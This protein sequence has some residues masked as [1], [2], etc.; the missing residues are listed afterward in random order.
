MQEFVESIPKTFKGNH[1]KVK[2]LAEKNLRRTGRAIIRESGEEFT[3]NTIENVI[4]KML[5]GI[6]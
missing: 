5:K 3:Q 4:K 6:F 2:R 1:P